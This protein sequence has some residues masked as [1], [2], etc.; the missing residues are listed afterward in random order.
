MFWRTAELDFFSLAKAID[1]LAAALKVAEARPRDESVHDASIQR[2]DDRY[3]LCIK[4]PRRQLEAMADLP[5]EVDELGCRDMIR[6][7]VE[8][9]LLKSDVPWYGY[10]ELRNYYQSRLRSDESAHSVRCAASMPS[11]REGITCEIAQ[12]R[13]VTIQNKGAN[14]MVLRSFVPHHRA[15]AF[16]YPVVSRPGERAR[17]KPHSD[18]DLAQKERSLPH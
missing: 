15:Y 1:S 18:L 17:L 7:G 13:V 14:R 11:P 6:L 8:R 3:G 5:A 2:F 10:R 4:S 9:G 16:G 12:G